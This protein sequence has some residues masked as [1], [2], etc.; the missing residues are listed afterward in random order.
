MKIPLVYFT[1]SGNTLYA[2][3]IVNKGFQKQNIDMELIP[4]KRAEKH[5]EILDA[6]IIGIASP[7]YE[8]NLSRVIRSWMTTIPTSED[9]KKVFF[10]DT[11]GGMP[12]DA[13]KIAEKMM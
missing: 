9:E 13:I 12:C 1:A 3:K 5:P 2:C 7:I 10:I 11:S 6:D 8:F 4:V